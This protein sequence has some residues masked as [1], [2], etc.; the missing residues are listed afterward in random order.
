MQRLIKKL[1]GGVVIV[2][3]YYADGLDEDY[4]EWICRVHWYK[5]GSSVKIRDQEY[6]NLSDTEQIKHCI[7]R[8]FEDA[9]KISW[10]K[11]NKL[12]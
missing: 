5:S 12:T 7:D 8:A 2:A 10:E 11:A 6:F 1:N 3:E 9:K 4:D